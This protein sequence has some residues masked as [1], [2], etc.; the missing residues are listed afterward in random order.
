MVIT[1][2][3]AKVSSPQDFFPD[4]DPKQKP[5]RPEPADYDD[6][7]DESLCVSCG[8]RFDEHSTKDI[9]QCA[10]NELRGEIPKK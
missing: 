5:T 9:V 6:W 2:V 7:T 3:K 8:L 1:W 10:L 4:I